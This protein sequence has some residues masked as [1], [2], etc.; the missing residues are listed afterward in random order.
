MI[1]LFG[2]TVVDSIRG[3]GTSSEFCMPRHF[4]M[5]LFLLLFSLHHHQLFSGIVVGLFTITLLALG[6][7]GAASH[8]NL[9][10][11]DAP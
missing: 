3:C 4:T 5:S 10:S 6:A 2:W 1:C 7:G 9:S 11:S 8:T